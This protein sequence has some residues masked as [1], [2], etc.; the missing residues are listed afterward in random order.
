MGLRDEILELLEPSLGELVGSAASICVVLQFFASLPSSMPASPPCSDAPGRP[1][2]S[3]RPCIFSQPVFEPEAP[4]NNQGLLCPGTKCLGSVEDFLELRPHIKQ[5]RVEPMHEAGATGLRCRLPKPGG[6][7]KEAMQ[8]V[9]SQEMLTSAPAL[10]GP[11]PQPVFGPKAPGALQEAPGVQQASP[12]FECKCKPLLVLRDEQVCLARNSVPAE[13][14]DGVAHPI[15]QRLNAMSKVRG[16]QLPV[17]LAGAPAGPLPSDA[18]QLQSLCPPRWIPA[19]R[20]SAQQVVATCQDT[21]VPQRRWKARHR[22][23]GYRT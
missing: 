6:D 7:A 9:F 23:R 5:P 17:E 16:Q 4:G 19:S 2:E 18:V 15:R 21:P 10:S 13:H 14:G 3:S 12:V 8:A 1:S 11:H 20:A 22:A